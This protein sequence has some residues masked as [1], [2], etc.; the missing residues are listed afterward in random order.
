MSYRDRLFLPHRGWRSAVLLAVFSIMSS[1]CL[2]DTIPQN[3]NGQM[4]G[5]YDPT[6]NMEELYTIGANDHHLIE[7]DVQTNK[8]TDIT[9]LLSLP[10]AFSPS[11]S[12]VYVP[13][14]ATT[15][16]FF[17]CGN[18]T[19]GN[20]QGT[21]YYVRNANGVY[22]DVALLTET[23]AVNE[24]QSVSAAFDPSTNSL[25]VAYQIQTDSAYDGFGPRGEVMELTFKYPTGG[26]WTRQNL[27]TAI[28]RTQEHLETQVGNYFNARYGQMQVSFD[29][30]GEGHIHLISYI[31]GNTADKSEDLMD[32]TSTVGVNATAGQTIGTYTG[33]C[34]TAG[35][36]PTYNTSQ[37]AE[38][39]YY[40]G[41]DGYTHQLFFDGSWQSLD[42]TKAAAGAPKPANCGPFAAIYNPLLAKTELFY[43]AAG[44]ASPNKLEIAVLN[45][46]GR[47]GWQLMGAYG[48][49]T[50]GYPAGFPMAAIYNQSTRNLDVFYVGYHTP[51]PNPH[52]YE[53]SHLASGGYTVTLLN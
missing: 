50:V 15:Y 47:G 53:L 44:S 9:A 6:R 39:L 27:Y 31:P 20:R 52:L 4:V 14:T 17:L 45:G 46:Q 2:A 38:E 37:G 12:A 1:L 51:D 22:S 34:Q 36:G 25:E 10:T 32:T 5:V 43:I 16:I 30:E 33:Y 23:Q 48:N 41:T 24:W 21:I 28:S 19:S 29:P 26:P 18:V 8:Y 3:N 11:V 7:Y 42:V 13:Y 49:S 35:Y 40:Y